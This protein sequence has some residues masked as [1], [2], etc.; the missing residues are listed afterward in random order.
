MGV[1]VGFGSIDSVRFS[2]DDTPRRPYDLAW[3]SRTH[4]HMPR[5]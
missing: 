2:C 4:P 3:E 5:R 1:P